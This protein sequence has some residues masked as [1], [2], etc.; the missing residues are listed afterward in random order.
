MTKILWFT[1]LSGTGKT[2]L[3]KILSSNLSKLNHK[4]KI[5]DGDDFRKKK[6]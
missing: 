3:A 1:G 4:V 2:T 5:I 6:K